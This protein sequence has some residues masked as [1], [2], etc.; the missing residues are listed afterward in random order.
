VSGGNGGGAGLLMLLPHLL[1]GRGGGQ[2]TGRVG[3]LSQGAPQGLL[4]RG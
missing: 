4:Q 1:R 3:E 2:E